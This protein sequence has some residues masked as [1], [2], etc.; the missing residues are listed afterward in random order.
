[1]TRI[2]SLWLSR[3]SK[4]QRVRSACHVNQD[5]VDTVRVFILDGRILQLFA[6]DSNAGFLSGE[7]SDVELLYF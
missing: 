3:Y 4:L 6:L 1:M 2:L 5:K 7:V